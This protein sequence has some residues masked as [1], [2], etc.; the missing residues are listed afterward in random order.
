[1]K[2]INI[3]GID[4][5]GKE[6][7]SKALEKTLHMKG[8]RVKRV[9]FPNYEGNFGRAINDVL[10]G[11]CGE[12]PKLSHELISPLYTLDRLS[13]FLENIKDLFDNYD[14]VI[15]D[16]SFYSNFMY[17]ASKIYM[18][19]PTFYNH[20][21]IKPAILEWLMKNGTWELY[22]T[23]LHH[24]EDIQTFVLSLSEEDSLK[25][26]ENR[27][28]KD[29]NEVNRGYLAECKKFTA[30]YMSNEIKKDVSRF[31]K[32]DSDYAVPILKYY[33]TNVHSIEVTHADDPKDIPTATMGTVSKICEHLGLFIENKKSEATETIRDWHR[34]NCPH[35]IN[36]S[37]YL[38]ESVSAC[39]ML[40]AIYYDFI[41]KEL[42]R[43]KI[44]NIHSVGVGVEAL[45]AEYNSGEDLPNVIWYTKK[46]SSYRYIFNPRWTAKIIANYMLKKAFPYKVRFT[47]IPATKTFNIEKISGGV[48]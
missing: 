10:M 38:N 22:H 45:C 7:V 15:C 2:I 47:Y 4:A 12:A 3:E 44:E 36:L 23:G 26:L 18:K 14:Y 25:Q 20:F 5:V 37:N 29:T 42:M 46:E 32:S 35:D 33:I 43:A 28:V 1:M 11:K 6:T 41:R 8:F 19:E 21:D 17:Q 9:E 40:S 31:I 39:N 13:Y 27:S 24:C 48:K 16:R 34:D 30:H